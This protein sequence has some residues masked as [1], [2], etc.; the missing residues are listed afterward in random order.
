MRSCEKRFQQSVLEKGVPHHFAEWLALNCSVASYAE[1]RQNKEPGRLSDAHLLQCARW[2]SKNH[3]CLLDDEDADHEVPNAAPTTG[4]EVVRWAHDAYPD[5]LQLGL[6]PENVWGIMPPHIK[7]EVSLLFG[8]A[9]ILEAGISVAPRLPQPKE[10][11]SSQAEKEKFE[12]DV[13]NA[14]VE[15]EEYM[16]NGFVTTRRYAVEYEKIYRR[17]SFVLL[18]TLFETNSVSP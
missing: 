3:A 12:K 15:A 13:V 14:M 2:M 5:T 6:T 1:S 10:H 7:D 8:K 16:E 18:G 17:L 4:R 9:A 11:T